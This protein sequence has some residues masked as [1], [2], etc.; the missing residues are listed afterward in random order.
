MIMGQRWEKMSRRTV[1]VIMTIV[2]LMGML[3]LT[4]NLRTTQASPETILSLDPSSIIDPTLTPGDIFTVDVLV[5]DV[6]YLYA[7]QVNM[8]FNPTVLKIFDIVEG[9]FLK[10]QPQG[11]FGAEKI[12]NEDGWALL[13][14]TTIGPY[15]GVSGSGKLAVVE[16]QVLAEGESILQFE[17]EPFYIEGTGTWAYPT[18]LLQQFS[19]VSPPM[20]NNLYPP[21]ELTTQNGYFNNFGAVVVSST[22][23]IKPKVL[24]LKSK[25]RW[26]TAFIELPEGYEKGDIDI[27]TVMLNGE[28]PAESHPTKIG[29][30]DEAGISDLM[31]KFDRQDLIDILS[32]GEATLTITGKVNDTPFEGSDTIRV[33]GK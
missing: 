2:V 16:F 15:V 17:T 21:E 8:S 7:W 12:E 25:G 19:P 23:N 10:S 9:D 11:T 14:W 30:F 5:S 3:M 18:F 29:V 13:G 6:E 28:I 20:W 32:A 1:S 4:A 31:V 22:I 27:S 33:I 26:I 24:N